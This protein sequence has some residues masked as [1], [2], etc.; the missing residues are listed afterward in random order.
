MSHHKPAAPC[1]QEDPPGPTVWAQFT[2]QSAEPL[3]LIPKSAV[4]NG[5]RKPA[6]DCP[7][8]A[9]CILARALLYP[10][11][12]HGPGLHGLHLCLKEKQHRART[13]NI[14]FQLVFSTASLPRDMALVT[15][16]RT[17]YES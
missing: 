15:V 7:A 4:K 16:L 12:G 8:H 14:N 1:T 2:L 10:A 6:G 5:T 11:R 17:D 3:S 13:Q 9:L